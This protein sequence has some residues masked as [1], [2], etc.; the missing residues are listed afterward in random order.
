MKYAQLSSQTQISISVIPNILWNLYNSFIRLLSISSPCPLICQHDVD[1]VTVLVVDSRVQ[2]L[3]Y[4]PE[5]HNWCSIVLS[6]LAI[7]CVIAGIATAIYILGWVEDGT[8]YSFKCCIATERAIDTASRSRFPF[9]LRRRVV[10][11]EWQTNDIRWIFA[12]RAD[13]QPPTSHVG[14]GLAFCIPVRWWWPCRFR[15]CQWLDFDTR[16]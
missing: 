2:D 11:L 4:P 7:G 14:V 5:G 1:N 6:L 16:Y 15:H 8:T 12:R 3:G 13:A 9:Q 10:I